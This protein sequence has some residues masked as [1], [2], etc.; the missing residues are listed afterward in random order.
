MLRRALPAV[1][2]VLLLSGA[3]PARSGSPPGSGEP[4][5]ASRAAN[6]VLLHGLGR[7]PDSMRA[8]A[9]G[10]AAQGYAVHNLGY[11]SRDATLAELAEGL[12]DEIERCCQD[13][14]VPLHFVTHSMGG[15]LLRSLLDGDR[16][17]GNLG[18]VVMLA[19]PNQGSEWVDEL[20][21][22]A[23]FRL[24]GPAAAELGTDDRSAPRRLGPVDFEL[25]VLAGNRSWNPLG[26]WL[27][28]GADDGTVAVAHARVA[29]MR[30]F[31]VVPTSHHRILRDRRALREVVYF[32]EHGRFRGPRESRDL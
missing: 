22:R 26:S 15:I 24:A 21:G 2:A 16:R 3:A 17:P 30:D 14:D 27:I 28:P 1:V 13:P 25:G 19:P 18:R 20:R 7:S 31:R 32:L 4:A 29:G 9:R 5:H 6:V 10:L 8:L 11:P 23:L 12:A